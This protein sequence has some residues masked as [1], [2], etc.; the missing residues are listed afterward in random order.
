M[1]LIFGLGRLD[2]LPVADFGLRSGMRKHYAL[3]DLPKKE[4]MHELATTWKPYR[5]IGTWYIW[6]SL[7]GVPQSDAP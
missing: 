7:G 3:A 4:A 1:F 6:R 5:S 2:V